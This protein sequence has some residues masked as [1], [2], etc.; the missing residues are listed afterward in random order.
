MNK[1]TNILLLFG[2]TSNIVLYLFFRINLE[3]RINN[4]LDGAL[5]FASSNL[6]RMTTYAMDYTRSVVTS[7]LLIHSTNNTTN[8]HSVVADQKDVFFEYKDSLPFHYF[9]IQGVPY[10][11][12]GC[13]TISISSPFPRGGYVTQIYPDSIVINNKYYFT[14]STIKNTNITSSSESLNPTNLL[15]G[16]KNE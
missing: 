15:L 8:D 12:L 13:I 7:N 2:I 11:R 10:A 16:K 9:E 1:F 14:N 3:R 4:R 6:V 5:T